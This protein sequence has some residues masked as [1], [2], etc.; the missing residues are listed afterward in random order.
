MS[1][2]QIEIRFGLFCFSFT[3]FI[4]VEA[5][6]SYLMCSLSLRLSSRH[7]CLPPQDLKP[8]FHSSRLH[9]LENPEDDVS[10]CVIQHL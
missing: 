1:L 3:Y 4:F 5:I 9:G 2:S 10:Y 6:L 7:D 8:R